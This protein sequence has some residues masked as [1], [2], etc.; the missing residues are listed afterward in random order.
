MVVGVRGTTCKQ[1]DPTSWFEGRKT[2][3]PEIWLCRTLIVCESFGALRGGQFVH[4][5]ACQRRIER[6]VQV[7]K[8]SKKK[9]DLSARAVRTDSFCFGTRRPLGSKLPKYRAFRV[10]ML[11]IGS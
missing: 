2:G 1:K 11:G 10:S 9:V 4:F 6:T 8:P 5:K 3:I 7:S